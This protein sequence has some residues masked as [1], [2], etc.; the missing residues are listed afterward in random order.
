MVAMAD[1]NVIRPS[2]IERSGTPQQCYV[3]ELLAAE[4]ERP[5]AVLAVKGVDSLVAWVKAFHRSARVQQVFAC[6][7]I[8]LQVF[9]LY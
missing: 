4:G 3:L 6:A 7:R 5:L 2:T 1:V 8:T 9:Q